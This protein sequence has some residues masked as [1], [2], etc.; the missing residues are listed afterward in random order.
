MNPNDSGKFTVEK[1]RKISI[2]DYIRQFRTQFKEAVVSSVAESV[3]TEIGIATTRTGFGG[4]RFWF[5]CPHC[6]R[7]IGIILVHPISGMIGC[8]RCLG[9]DYTSRRYKGMAE[10]K[11]G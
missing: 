6:E 9:V 10:A 2:S 7:K 4:I 1:C 8:R 5:V 11:L 3:G